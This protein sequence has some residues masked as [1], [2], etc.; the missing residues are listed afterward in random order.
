MALLSIAKAAGQE[1]KNGLIGKFFNF[2]FSNRLHIVAYGPGT[3]AFW[4]QW[5]HVPI[6]FLGYVI[7]FL[8]VWFGYILNMYFDVDEDIANA[9]VSGYRLVNHDKS[10]IWLAAFVG[11]GALMLAYWHRPSYAM[12]VFVSLCLG[13]FYS[14]PIQMG[15]RFF[16]L[17]ANYFLKNAYS[18]FNWSVVLFALTLLYAKQAVEGSQLLLCCAICFFM[19]FFVELLWDV[20]DVEGDRQS[21][22]NT[23]ATRFGVRHA[24]GFLH[25]VNMIILILAYVGVFARILAPAFVLVLAHTIF[26]ALF[27]RWYRDAPNKKIASHAYVVIVAIELVVIS[28]ADMAFE[29]FV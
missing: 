15:T 8:V 23:V 29:R 4:N 14:W 27:L 16:R 11:A 28:V 3:I 18:A 2:L 19:T 6:D 12:F 17:K 9:E 1:S 13:A 25:L 21:N 20:R 22:V 24:I 26:A 10:A 7:L 5:M